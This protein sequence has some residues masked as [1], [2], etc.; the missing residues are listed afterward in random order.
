VAAGIGFAAEAL[1]RHSGLDPESRVFN[2]PD[3]ELH[4]RLWIPA[5]AGMAI[6]AAVTGVVGVTARATM[7]GG[8][9]SVR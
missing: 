2:W 4:E 3:E 8:R 1:N 5:V 7:R 6:G 9:H